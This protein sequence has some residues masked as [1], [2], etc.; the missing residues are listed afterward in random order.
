MKNIALVL[1]SSGSLIG[2]MRSGGSTDNVDSA[3]AAA[4]SQESVSDESDIMI[5][6]VD[7][8]SPT[9]LAAATDDQIA[10]TIAANVAGRWPGGCATVVQTGAD[11]TITY[12]DC[13]GP[14]GLVHVTGELDLTISVSG[15]A[16]SVH[17]S[18]SDLEV[19]MATIDFTADGTLTTS[20]TMQSLA[21]TASGSGTGPR[22]NAIDHNGNYTVTWD[23]SD[24]CR[25]IDGSWS[26]DLTTPVAT[27]ERANTVDL[28]RCGDSCPT[29]TFTHKYLGGALLTLTFNGTAT[30][31]WAATVGATST[32]GT[33]ALT[34]M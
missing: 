21:V 15:A 18:A 24:T 28:M 17:A 5:A 31:S 8:S 11:V 9:G 34:C 13:T 29:G 6:S 33:I 16:I 19:N 14:R 22:G 7:G 32:S 12:N 25:T 26:T 30:A 1:L 10:A 2:C 3:S 27:A 20:G 23:S 4:D